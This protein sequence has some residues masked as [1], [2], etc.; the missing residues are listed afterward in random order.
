M[1]MRATPTEVPEKSLPKR[2]KVRS[3]VLSLFMVARSPLNWL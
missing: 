1:L 3:S 2:I